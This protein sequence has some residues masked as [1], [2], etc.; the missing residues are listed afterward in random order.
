[1]FPRKTVK[2]FH[3]TK[4][5]NVP[6]ILKDGLK[7]RGE[8]I[9]LSDSIAGAARWK[10]ATMQGMPIAIVE[11]EVDARTVRDG[12]DHSPAM[13]KLFGAG[14]SLWSSKNIPSESVIRIHFRT[15]HKSFKSTRTRAKTGAAKSGERSSSR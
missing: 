11:V 6:D 5:E 8:G 9:Y 7:S 10:A 2:L 13:Q 14:K 12:N 3:A 4:V 15:I 1:M